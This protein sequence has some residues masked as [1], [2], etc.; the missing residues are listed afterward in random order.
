MIALADKAQQ[1]LYRRYHRMTE[2]G[3]PTPKAV[4]AI[5]RELTGYIWAALSRRAAPTA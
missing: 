2:R 4:T 5:A 3:I 1:R